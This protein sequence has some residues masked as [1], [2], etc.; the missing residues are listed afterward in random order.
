MQ[1]IEP[2]KFLIV[3]FP[4]GTE[5]SLSQDSLLPG[6]ELNQRPPKFDSSMAFVGFRSVC[7]ALFS[8]IIVFI[9]G[10][11]YILLKALSVS[12]SWL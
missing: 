7:G 12:R 1:N 10:I 6:R 9:L 5:E 2:A 4:R 3:Y 8:S 11:N